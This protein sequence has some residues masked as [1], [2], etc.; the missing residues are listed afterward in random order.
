[1]AWHCGQL[2]DEAVSSALHTW[3]D[4]TFGYKLSGAASVRAKNVC[5]AL[6]DGHTEQR[7]AGVVQLFS[8]PHPPREAVSPALPP[9]V[10]RIGGLGEEEADTVPASTEEKIVIQTEF[11][12]LQELQDLESLHS[13]LVESPPNCR[14]TR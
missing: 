7:S 5:L 11:N 1:M 14:H 8:L 12:C 9:V 6:V 4:L 10:E 3:I 2:E 13:F